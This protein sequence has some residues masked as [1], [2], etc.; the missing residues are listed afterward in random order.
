MY[1]N[2]RLQVKWGDKTSQLFNVTNGVRQGG[3]MSPLLFGIYMDGLLHELKNLGIGCQLGQYFCGAVGYADDIILLCP[4]LSGLRKMVNVCERYAQQHDVLFNGKKSKL[5]VFGSKEPKDVNVSVNGQNVPLCDT[6][7]H[8]GHM[9]STIDKYECVKDGVKRFNSSVN[10]F[11]AKFGGLYS[12]VKNKLFTQYCCSMYGAQLWPLWHENTEMLCTQWRNALRRIWKLPYNTH[13]DLLP[14]VAKNVPLEI[15]LELRFARFY[16]SLVNSKNSIVRFVAKMTTYGWRSTMGMN[17][18]HL[19]AKYNLC[20]NELIAKSVCEL[21]QICKDKWMN[22][23]DENYKAYASIICDM[24]G[25][26]KGSYV[27]VCRRM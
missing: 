25:M 24:I 21:K 22:S 18:R 11:F 7:V 19:L 17:V 20:L 13:K 4:T 6:A 14:L 3:V 26:K 5:L 12:S 23:M 2:Q 27:N 16:Q 1:T 10:S 9:L 8:L 15:S